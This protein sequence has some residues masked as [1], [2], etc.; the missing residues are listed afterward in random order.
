MWSAKVSV[1][2]CDFRDQY[3][4][5]PPAGFV[6]VDCGRGCLYHT[7]LLSRSTRCLGKIQRFYKADS[8]AASL[9]HVF[10]RRAIPNKLTNIYVG[11]DIV[12]GV[13][14]VHREGVFLHQTV[15]MNC[16]KHQPSIGSRN[17]WAR[18][19]RG[20][21]HVRRACF[22]RPSNDRRA[23]RRCLSLPSRT[24]R[25]EGLE[26]VARL[27]LWFCRV[28]RELENNARYDQAHEPRNKTDKHQTQRS[29]RMPRLRPQEERFRRLD[30]C[31]EIE[32]RQHLRPSRHLAP[33]RRQSGTTEAALCYCRQQ[34]Y[35]TVPQ[36]ARQRQRTAL[37]ATF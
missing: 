10:S 30:A 14:P 31:V 15:T 16:W 19:K 23:M 22:R 5:G 34:L 11:E 28:S 27:F 33:V 18:G 3:V 29:E 25:R 7:F 32:R 1:G 17:A 8:S 24:E 12:V 13:L 4:T 35:A 20:E 2:M 37:L 9:R 6:F 26:L 36:M 21:K